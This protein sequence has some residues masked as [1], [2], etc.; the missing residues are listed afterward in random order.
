MTY[1]WAFIICGTICALGQIIYEYTKL[2]AGH[3]TSLFVSL[4]CFLEFF[5][6]YDYLLKI[7]GVGASLPITNFGHSLMHAALEGMK[8]E[9]LLGIAKNML[10]TTS[11]GIVTAVTLSFFIAII[12][13]SK[14]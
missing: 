6:V 12:F 2:S 14:E 3:I 13:K 8:N 5:G 10:S 7:G 4:G 11:A 1:F 9:G